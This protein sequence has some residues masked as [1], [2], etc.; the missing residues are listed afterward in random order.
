MAD[1]QLVRLLKNHCIRRGEFTLSSGLQSSWLR[2]LKIAHK[3]FRMLGRKLQELGLQHPP[4]GIPLGG[5]LLAQGMALPAGYA[6]F[7]QIHPD[8]SGTVYAPWGVGSGW[9]LTTCPKC[10]S[11][12]SPDFP[13][14]GMGWTCDCEWQRRH[15]PKNCRVALV[16][17]V[18]TTERQFKIAKQAF[19]V[20]GLIVA[21]YFVVLDRRPPEYRTLEVS[22]LVAAADLDMEPL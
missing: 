20:G 11:Q 13:S 3:D 22:S 7:I 12:L 2:D 16:D 19:T 9:D 1:Q 4:V 10:Q 8:E 15:D 21:A 14:G 6:G 17:D 5:L 18:V